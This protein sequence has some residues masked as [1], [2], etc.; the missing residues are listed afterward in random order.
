MSVNSNLL[1]PALHDVMTFCSRK[2]FNASQDGNFD[3]ALATIHTV[4]KTL[5]TA[6][7]EQVKSN[8]DYISR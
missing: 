1:P 2:L 4:I 8:D 6:L 7:D 5:Q 3:Y